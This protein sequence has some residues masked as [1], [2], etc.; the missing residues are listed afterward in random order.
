MT[1]SEETPK[2]PDADPAEPIAP[3]EEYEAAPMEW[4]TPAAAVSWRDRLLWAGVLV[5]LAAV[6]YSPALQGTFIWDDDHY[7]YQNTA[8]TEGGLDKIWTDWSSNPKERISPQYYPM[9]FTTFWIEARLWGTDEATGRPR[10]LG[11]HLTN[12]L[13]H[14]GNAVLV[15]VIL[16]RL[17][18]PGSWVAAAVFA[19]HPLNVESV[20]WVSERKNVLSGLFALLSLLAYL[21][22]AGIGRGWTDAATGDVEQEATP[23]LPRRQWGLY[24]ASLGAFLLAMFSKTV[25]ATLP[26]V[27]VVILWWKCRRFPWRDVACLLPFVFV[28]IV[29]GT[30][31]ANIEHAHIA[32]VLARQPAG[33]PK[34]DWGLSA[35][36]RVLVSGRAV[37]FYVAKVLVPVNLTFIYPRWKPWEW[38]PA[39]W[40]WPIGVVAVAV[41]LW[42]A[43]R[44]V[45]KGPLA[46]WLIFVGVL[47]PA[48]GFTEFFPQRYSFVADHFAYLASVALIALIVAGVA[49]AVSALWPE[50][51]PAPAPPE[52]VVRAGESEPPL[53]S[54]A[55]SR[56]QA[57]FW[58][59]GAVL[60]VLLVGSFVH[61]RVFDNPVVLWQDTLAKNPSSWMAHNNLGYQ[62]GMVKAREERQAGDAAAAN[63]DL[64]EAARQ[65]E[66]TIRL[67]PNHEFAYL[68]WGN[69]LM[70]LGRVKEA[71]PK[72]EKAMELTPKSPDVHLQYG[73]ALKAMGSMVAREHAATRAATTRAATTQAAATQPLA[74]AAAVPSIRPLAS[75]RGAATT[76]SL[77]ATRPATR[78]W[79]AAERPW[80]EAAEKQFRE[81]IALAP[82]F[83]Q[84]HYQL[85]L[86]LLAQTRTAEAE[87][88]LETAWRDRPKDDY[89]DAHWE[90]GM[91]LAREGRVPAAIFHLARVSEIQ[92]ENGEVH[93]QLGYLLG[94][95]NHIRESIDQFR[96]A[97]MINPNDKLAYDGLNRIV[98]ELEAT[99]RRAASQAATQATSGRATTGAATTRASRVL[100]AGSAAFETT[101]TAGP[102]GATAR[103]ASGAAR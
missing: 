87:A 88:E 60:V 84:A 86:L 47:T 36:E 71:M 78:P 57:M 54:P 82:Q 66:E 26:A 101:E 99:T 12:I 92:P 48:L 31:T 69:V 11:F 58:A 16:R 83:S 65:F 17:R 45:G 89:A 15:W 85:A 75:T 61:A 59:V 18:A 64:E 37:W 14:A 41:L 33:E 1:E 51:A 95:V 2:R 97:L 21:H 98:Q 94:Q 53:P 81:A 80:M 96:T 9:V 6:A 10:A 3:E 22:F 35:G 25:V 56:A 79:G 24:A 32:D 103:P 13:L 73:L 72:F 4:V 67:R 23:D 42:A 63:A 74:A 55:S 19:V 39:A 30:L 93:T 40:L 52:P 20:A 50:P 90:L 34:Q 8:V 43:R 68:N 5:L 62:L 77:A 44:A 46:A 102:R 29:L 91:L 38:G 28:A 27:I 100:P 76:R 70:Q 49:R 7:V